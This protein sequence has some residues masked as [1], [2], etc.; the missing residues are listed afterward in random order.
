[1][2]TTWP[3]RWAAREWLRALDMAC[4]CTTSKKPPRAR[5]RG[6]EEYGYSK[7]LSRLTN[8]TLQYETPSECRC[9]PAVRLIRVMS[10]QSLDYHTATLNGPMRR[11]RWALAAGAA[12]G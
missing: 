3:S 9:A 2:A 8:D 6:D 7:N 5:P 12:I 10:Q 1:M 11:S 4:S